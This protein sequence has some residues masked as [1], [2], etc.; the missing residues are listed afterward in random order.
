ME[1]AHF[2]RGNSTVATAAAGEKPQGEAVWGRYAQVNLARRVQSTALHEM[3]NWVM[4]AYFSNAFN[5][6][7]R[8]AMLEEVATC[9]PALTSFVDSGEHP[10]IT[11]SR[12]FQQG[13]PMGPAMF[14]LP[15]RKELRRNP[16]GEG[17]EAFAY[18]DD[19]TLDRA[20]VTASTITTWGQRRQAANARGGKRLRQQTPTARRGGTRQA[21]RSRQRYRRQGPAS[22]GKMT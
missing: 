1:A 18:V 21:L 12:G 14:C 8:A 10:T 19:E 15:L 4:L 13:G 7:K 3:G 11:H 20:K 22:T 17:L 9:V 6:I 5:A 2:R 16:T